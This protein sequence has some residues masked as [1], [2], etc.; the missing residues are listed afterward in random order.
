MTIDPTRQLKRVYEFLEEEYFS[1]DLENIEQAEVYE[2]D[3]VYFRERTS[4][5]T[6]PSLLSK[7]V[8][9]RMCS[10]ELLNHI[11]KDNIPYYKMFYPEVTP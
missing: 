3:A 11:Y 1:H 7:P 2:H 6:H 10:P 5:K 9:P 4:H 8:E